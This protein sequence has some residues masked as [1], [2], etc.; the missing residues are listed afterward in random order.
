VINILKLAYTYKDK[1]QEIYKS[2][3]FQEKY[4]YYN[5]STY[6]NYELKIEDDSWNYIQM[7]SVDDEDNIRGYFS[8]TINRTS[9]IVDALG[10]INFYDVNVVFAKDMYQFIKDLFL[11]FNFRKIEFSVVI[12][13]PIEKMYDKYIHKYNGNIIGI[14]RQSIKL[15]DDKL[16]DVKLYEIFKD[17]CIKLI[18]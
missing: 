4:K 9:N 6:W 7:V 8:A 17:D 2:I 14:K 5:F 18:K 13:N 16:Y 10:I 12:G 3:I 15:H 1:L 11:K